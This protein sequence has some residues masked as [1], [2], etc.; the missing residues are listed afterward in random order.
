MRDLPFEL[1]LQR[2]IRLSAL[3]TAGSIVAAVYN[4]HLDWAWGLALGA[5]AAIWSAYFLARRV[6]LAA[7]RGRRGQNELLGSLLARIVTLMGA[8]LVAGLVPAINVLATAVGILIFSMVFGLVAGKGL[9]E[10]LKE[11]PKRKG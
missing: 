2:S 11:N 5:G 4:Q 8:L 1:Y 3:L 10:V 7:Q 6:K 9:L